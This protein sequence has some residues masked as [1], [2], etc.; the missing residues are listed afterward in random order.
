MKLMLQEQ[1]LQIGS[2]TKK[3]F[4]EQNQLVKTRIYICQTL[5]FRNDVSVPESLNLKG[6]EY[7]CCTYSEYL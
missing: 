5:N 3:T 6:L 7:S 4:Q 2:T 1:S